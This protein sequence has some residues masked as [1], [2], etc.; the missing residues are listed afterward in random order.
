MDSEIHG[1]S[2]WPNTKLM[3][4]YQISGQVLFYWPRIKLVAM[5]QIS[6]ENQNRGS[7]MFLPL[8]YY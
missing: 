4:K 5:N 3:A 2:K 1:N 6:G 8:K 7:Y